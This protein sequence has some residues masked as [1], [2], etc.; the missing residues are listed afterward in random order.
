VHSK[1]TNYDLLGEGTLMCDQSF[2]VSCSKPE[3]LSVDVLSLP[4]SN[5]N[6]QDFICPASF[7]LQIPESSS[8][9]TGMQEMC[10]CSFAV[11]LDLLHRD[12]GKSMMYFQALM[13]L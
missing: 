5:T 13:I 11:M 12:K 7:F 1:K 6:S 8:T 10:N 9:A 4:A 3:K 2:K